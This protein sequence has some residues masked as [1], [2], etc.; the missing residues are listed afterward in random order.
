MFRSIKP[1]FNFEP[2][3]TEGE[4]QA[5]AL[6]FVR[7]ISGFHKPSR[8]NQPSLDRAFLEVAVAAEK[9]IH[10]LETKAEPRSRLGAPPMAQ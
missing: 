8:T 7:K 9:L 3:V 2:P 10:A 5:A 6:Q 4:V 1:L